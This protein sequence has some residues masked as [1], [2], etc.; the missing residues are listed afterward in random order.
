MVIE[1]VIALR[2]AAGA[3][4]PA[5]SAPAAPALALPLAGTSAPLLAAS[6]PQLPPAPAPVPAAPLDLSPAAGVY[7]RRGVGLLV[8]DAKDSTALHLSEGTRRAHALI[9]DAVDGAEGAAS[10]FDGRV[11]RRLGD[12][13]LIAFPT[14]G[15]ALAAAEAI[16]RDSAARAAAGA[17]VPKL[18]VGVHAGRVL[19]DATGAAPE[20]YGRAVEKTL[21]LAASADGGAIATEDGAEGAPAAAARAPDA[22]RP[23][24][25]VR[26]DMAATMFAS[27]DGWTTAYERYGR[28]RS[29]A[30][31]KAFH[32]FVR[33]AVE[34]RGGRVV[35]TEGE[36]VM[37]SFP[38][39]EAGVKAAAAIQGRMADLRAAAPLGRLMRARVGLSWGRVIRE[40]RAGEVDYF[41]NTVNAAARLMRLSGDGEALIGGAAAREPGV[42]PLLEGAARET[43]RLK[44]FDGEI[45]VARLK[46]A[47]LP[48]DAAASARLRKVAREA[49]AA[50]VP[51]PDAR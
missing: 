4:A 45:P 25:S 8:F 40:E 41:G 36:T 30:A 13:S 22:P 5:L 39:A 1:T 38:T 19:V 51:A 24:D 26:V 33:E 9:R 14:Y 28:R 3:P 11:I 48:R 47:P 49:R 20:I 43:T 17:K 27:L 12:G 10:A 32:A 50:I 7:E 42:A 46:A 15:A 29:Y 18:R 37:A 21:A 34:R 23:V 35:K 31:V 16:Q 6:A 44:G 2:L